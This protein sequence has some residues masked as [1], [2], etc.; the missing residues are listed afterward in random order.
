MKN[1][2]QTRLQKKRRKSES[3]LNSKL[4]IFAWFFV[5]LVFNCLV[6]AVEPI[7]AQDIKE[8]SEFAEAYDT[9]QKAFVAVLDAEQAGVN[10][11]DFLS[12]LNIGT[13][14]LAQAKQS[15]NLGNVNEAMSKVEYVL[16]YA[17]GIEA[18]AAN[19]RN[20]VLIGNESAI[21]IRIA[22]SFLAG[23]S[24]ILVIFLIWKWFKRRYYKSLLNS[25][26]EVI[27]ADY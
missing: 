5:F 24:Y 17:K 1:L 23:F 21:Y 3:V 26:P 8:P 22:F 9:L 11:T 27:N 25:K 16:D 20:L 12:D 7:G 13:D 15:Y 18:K 2:Q 10:V 4:K 19:Q 6:Y 14:I